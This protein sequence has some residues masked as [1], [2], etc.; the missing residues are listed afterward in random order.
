MSSPSAFRWTA[1]QVTIKER[2]AK[3]ARELESIAQLVEDMIPKFKKQ[4]E[5]QFYLGIAQSYRTAARDILQKS[6]WG[7]SKLRGFALFH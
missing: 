1:S 2:H 5:R 6:W 3:K 7:K 4:E